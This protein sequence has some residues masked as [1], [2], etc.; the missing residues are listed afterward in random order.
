MN[1]NFNNLVYACLGITEENFNKIIRNLPDII[2][3]NDDLDFSGFECDPYYDDIE[4]KIVYYLLNTYITIKDAFVDEFCIDKKTIYI[5]D[6]ESKKDLAKIKS[7]LGD[8]TI[9][10]EEELIKDL[11]END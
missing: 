9:E 7:L 3:N 4:Y 6:V 8:W 10:N 2:K 11:E 1:N 5:Y